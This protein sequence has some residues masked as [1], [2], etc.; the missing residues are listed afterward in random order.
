MGPYSFE[1]FVLFP[2]ALSTGYFLPFSRA[3]AALSPPESRRCY[4]HR[5]WICSCAEPV[6]VVPCQELPI[7]AIS[8][9]RGHEGEGLSL[10]RVVLTAVLP[11][12]LEPVTGNRTPCA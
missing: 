4:R 9:L 1:Y 7:R 3:Y 5:T 10:I 2:F 11:L 8:R 12:L 6:V